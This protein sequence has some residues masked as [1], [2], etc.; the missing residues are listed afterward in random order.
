VTDLIHLPWRD[1]SLPLNGGEGP[2]IYTSLL[3]EEARALASLATGL[4]VL[5]VGAAAGFSTIA[6]AQAARFVTSVELEV[7]WVTHLAPRLA[8]L[9]RYGIHNVRHVTGSSFD[10]LPNMIK[11]GEAFGLVFL[12]GDHAYESVMKDATNAWLL[13]GASG[14]LACHDYLEDCCADVK[15]ALDDLFPIGPDYIIGTMAV[16]KK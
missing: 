5:E 7:G 12:D 10:I 15:P 11:S 1:V 2:G 3:L 9:T 13:L 8:N 6:L 16:Y 4:D 14:T